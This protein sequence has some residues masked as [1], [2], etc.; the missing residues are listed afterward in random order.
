MQHMTRLLSNPVTI[1]K[2]TSQPDWVAGVPAGGPWTELT[3]SVVLKTWLLGN[4]G[5]ATGFLGTNPLSAIRNAFCTP[6]WDSADKAA[7][8]FGGGHSDGSC[9]ALIKW[10]AMT[11]RYSL[12][13]PPTPARFYPPAYTAPNA[14]IAYPSGSNLGFF[15]TTT[16]LSDSRDLPFAAPFVAP[17][18][19]HTYSGLVA[20]NGRLQSYYGNTVSA[21]LVNGSWD[22]SNLNRIGPQL[23]AIQPNEGNE[24]LGEGT[25]AALDVSRGKVWICANPGSSGDN[26]RNHFV[27]VD[28]LSNVVE[29][30]VGLPTGA[31]DYSG[32]TGSESTC[33]HARRVYAFSG[34]GDPVKVNRGWYVD[35]DVSPVPGGATR[36][37]LSGD[38]PQIGTI[39]GGLQESVPCFSNGSFVFLWNYSTERDSL[40]RIDP[41][42]VSG[43]GTGGDPYMLR[44]TRIPLGTSGMPLPVSVYR[45]DYIPEWRV[46]LVLPS[47]EARWWALK[48]A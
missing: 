20:F 41:N 43:S 19:T 37:E 7:Y 14:G 10:N 30:L 22:C 38:V 21:N 13:I 34:R 25:Q 33:I 47:A 48:M 23:K 5:S 18:S 16:T 45:L 1:Y 29:A 39:S 11:L 2:V 6:A 15:Q 9:N 40:Y 46:V 3:G 24:R 17:Q 12:L 4:L 35:L 31:P 28:A 27:K 42:P 8:L 32:F 44:S 26:W 36:F